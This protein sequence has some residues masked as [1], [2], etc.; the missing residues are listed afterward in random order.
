MSRCCA[1]LAT[2][3]GPCMLEHVV[4]SIAAACQPLAEL[5]LADRQDDSPAR[6]T[7]YIVLIPGCSLPLISFAFTRRAAPQHHE[8]SVSAN[9]DTN[10]LGGPQ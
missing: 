10:Y 5:G 2:I 7:G 9:L 8:N 3:I 1:G 4:W 6:S